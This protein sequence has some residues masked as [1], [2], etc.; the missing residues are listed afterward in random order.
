M[1]SKFVTISQLS[2]ALREKTVTLDFSRATTLYKKVR[3]LGLLVDGAPLHIALPKRTLSA[4]AMFAGKTQ[5]DGARVS[6]HDQALVA[7]IKQLTQ[8]IAPILKRAP[9]P[10]GAEG[11]YFKKARD[12]E[13][14]NKFIQFIAANG[15]ELA[16]PIVRADIKFA[17]TSEGRIAK[18][19]AP[20]CTL[21]DDKEP[22]ETTYGSINEWIYTG[23]E[24]TL[25][26]SIALK[27]YN[28]QFVLGANCECVKMT[29]GPRKMVPQS[30]RF[31]QKDILDALDALEKEETS[32]RSSRAPSACPSDSEAAHAT[33]CKCQ[34]V[35]I[36]ELEEDPE[37]VQD[38]ETVEY[39]EEPAQAPAQPPRVVITPEMQ[40][41]LD[42]Q[43]AEH[44][45]KVRAEARKKRTTRA[46]GKS[47]DKFEDG[48]NTTEEMEKIPET[49]DK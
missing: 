1:S 8:Y 24:V 47:P 29:G 40:K 25:I 7:V 6:F 19:A 48:Y 34:P 42:K 15:S 21:R 13:I 33:A 3:F 5:F 38:N 23:R 18:D 28:G 49:D 46:K 41:R 45:A 27:L 14:A 36:E 20:K 16:Q 30:E 32:E 2:C 9:K 37:H 31:A 4:N 35:V 39:S 44:A 11:D 12:S 43:A 17:Y 10:D 26:I 22:V